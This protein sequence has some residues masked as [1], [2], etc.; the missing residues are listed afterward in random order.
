MECQL[1]VTFDMV[2]KCKKNKGFTLV[3]VMMTVAILS[4]GIVSIYEALFVSLDAYGYYTHYFNTSDWIGEKIWEVQSELINSGALNEEQTSGKIVRDHKAYDWL[5]T[6]SL[7]DPTQG[8]YKV[9]VILSW[10][11]GNKKVDTTREVYLLP[12]EL[13]IYNEEGFA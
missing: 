8:L 2:N 3:E 4:F 13:K 6:V 11:E 1:A 5:M 10:Q 9:R 7:L 12:P